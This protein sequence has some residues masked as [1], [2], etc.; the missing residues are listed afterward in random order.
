MD[1]G[2]VARRL[3][4]LCAP[5]FLIY[6][7]IPEDFLGVGREPLLAFTFAVLIIMEA[8]RLKKKQV[9]FGMRDYEAGQLSAYAWA[10]IGL[11]IAFLF[12]P[13]VFVIPAVI[14]IGW[15]DPLIGEMRKRKMKGYPHIPLLVYFMIT[16]SSLA[17][18]AEGLGYD[19]GLK[20]M[21]LISVT[22]SFVAIVVEK[23]TFKRVDDD[24]L[25]LVFPLL[26]TSSLYW[27][28]SQLA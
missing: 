26:A 22:G 20:E 23:P 7:F 14:G 8:I 15:I 27:L 21:I 25:M 6:Y 1:Y 2:H 10:T 5:V 16:L 17:L 4:H 24:F 11:T 9:F 3:F 19:I 28:M 13:Q 18:F 12:F